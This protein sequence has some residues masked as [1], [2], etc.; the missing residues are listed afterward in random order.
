M[1]NI[2]KTAIVRDSKCIDHEFSLVRVVDGYS[3]TWDGKP[4]DWSFTENGYNQAVW[5]FD[6]ICEDVLE[7]NYMNYWVN[8]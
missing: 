8:G 4:V 7:V 2:I 5:H 1:N 3:F 6:H